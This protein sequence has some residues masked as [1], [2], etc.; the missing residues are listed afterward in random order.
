[1]VVRFAEIMVCPWLSRSLTN[2]RRPGAAWH[3]ANASV[4][5]PSYQ[6]AFERVEASSDPVADTDLGV[7]SLDVV[8]RVTSRV[9]NAGA[10]RMV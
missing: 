1:M 8:A 6:S 4:L 7:G 2:T 3:E 10:S 9:S 5:G